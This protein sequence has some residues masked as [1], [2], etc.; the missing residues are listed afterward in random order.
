MKSE[1]RSAKVVFWLSAAGKVAS[2]SPLL[3]EF[4]EAH[5]GY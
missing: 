3:V 4:V 1:A 2:K 5:G